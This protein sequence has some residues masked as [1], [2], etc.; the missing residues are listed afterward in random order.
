MLHRLAPRNQR[1]WLNIPSPVIQLSILIS[2]WLT[3]TLRCAEAYNPVPRLT[4]HTSPRLG[5]LLHISFRSCCEIFHC[6]SSPVS[7]FFIPIFSRPGREIHYFFSTLTISP[8]HC[9]LPCHNFPLPLAPSSSPT[10]LLHRSLPGI[11]LNLV[12]FTT[13][14]SPF[15]SS[16]TE[17]RRNEFQIRGSPQYRLHIQNESGYE[18]GDL[19]RSF[20]EKKTKVKIS[21]KCNASFIF[22]MNLGMNQETLC[23]LLM[24]K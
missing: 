20:D 6:C 24:K 9:R 2:A 13:P 21:C 18:S 22:K 10:S 5:R 16:Y 19:V 17:I 4:F 15:F 23:V 12:F 7:S 1:D 3:R 14:P 11:S 8:T